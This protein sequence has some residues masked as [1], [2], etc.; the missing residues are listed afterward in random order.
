[1]SKHRVVIS[2]FPSFAIDTTSNDITLRILLHIIVQGLSERAI[3]ESIRRNCLNLV[4]FD[5]S[6]S[7]IEG[8]INNP[9]IWPL[10]VFILFRERTLVVIVKNKGFHRM[11]VH[12]IFLRYEHCHGQIRTNQPSNHTRRRAFNIRDAVV[13]RYKSI[14]EKVTD[15]AAR[16]NCTHIN[17]RCSIDITG[18]RICIQLHGTFME[19]LYKH[20]VGIAAPHKAA[21][22]ATAL[23]RHFPTM[24]AIFYNERCIGKRNKSARRSSNITLKMAVFQCQR[25]IGIANYT[26]AFRVSIIYGQVTNDGLLLSIRG[27]KFTKQ[28]CTI[29]NKQA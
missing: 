3:L 13:I 2:L 8:I 15:Q 5:S 28:S 19:I 23:R 25:K 29:R 9:F 21:H 20:Q 6:S 10:I 17:I 4:I 11:V 16:T 27:Q 7:Q 22:I 14:T 12:G 1:M 18:Y 26:T 24:A